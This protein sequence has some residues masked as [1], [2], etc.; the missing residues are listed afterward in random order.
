M[1]S[2]AYGRKGQLGESSWTLAEYF[3]L[4][5]PRGDLIRSIK[6]AERLL[7]R[8]SP[9]WRRVQDI[10]LVVQARRRR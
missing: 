6:R 7:R 3:L 10:K 8:G 1:M 5:G 9:A 2:V 4:V